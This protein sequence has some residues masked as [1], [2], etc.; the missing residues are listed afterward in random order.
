MKIP[1]INKGIEF[2]DL[3]SIFRDNTVVS[4]IPSYFENTESP[5]IC[6]KYNNQIR[7]TLLKFN[8]LVSDIDIVNYFQRIQIQMLCPHWLKKYRKAIASAIFQIID[9]RISFYSNN[10]DFLLAKLRF[11]CRHL[12]QGFQEFHRKYVLVPADKAANNVV[13]VWRPSY[14]NT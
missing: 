6:Y 11:S 3:P 12:K 10:L 9:K 5:I 13:V 1:F 14:I 2:V 8:K 7:N 4:S